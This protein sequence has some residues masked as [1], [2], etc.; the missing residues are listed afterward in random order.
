MKYQIS[1]QG[2]HCN[3]CKNLI[4]MSLEEMSDLSSINVE[5][6][7]AEFVS[8]TESAKLQSELQQVFTELPGY[9]YSNLESIN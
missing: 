1:I 9:S 7:R 5:E 2:M 8:D 4:K 6:G 3:G